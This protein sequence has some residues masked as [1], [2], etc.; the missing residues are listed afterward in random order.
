[1]R[2]MSIIMPIS[3]IPSLDVRESNN[4]NISLLFP[5]HNV[6]GLSFCYIKVD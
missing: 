4:V 6:T 2:S 3:S 5:M 1:M